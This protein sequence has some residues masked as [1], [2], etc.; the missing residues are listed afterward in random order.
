MSFRVESPKSELWPRWRTALEAAS[1][2]VEVLEEDPHGVVAH[3]IGREGARGHVTLGDRISGDGVQ[4]GLGWV[5]RPRPIA[6]RSPCVPLPTPVVRVHEERR[7][8]NPPPEREDPTEHTRWF[9]TRRSFDVDDDGVLDAI[10]PEVEPRDCPHEVEYSIYVMR[11]TCA[12]LVGRTLGLPHIAGPPRAGRLRDLRTHRRWGEITDRT[13][14]M[15]PHNVAT[16]HEVTT[17]YTAPRGTYRAGASSE[18]TGVC[19][20]CSMPSCR[21]VPT[22]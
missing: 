18:H 13:R 12:H 20:H 9:R 15:G 17:P 21:I 2:R 5:P 10:V 6:M 11:G 7:E 14:P 8:A 4:V 22:P 1:I 16:L 3:L 19:H